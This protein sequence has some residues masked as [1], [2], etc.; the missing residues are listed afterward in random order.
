MTT[1]F[2]FT[3]EQKKQLAA[4]ESMKREQIETLNRR[5]IAYAKTQDKIEKLTRE[6]A[7]LDLDRAYSQRVL[8]ATESRIDTIVTEACDRRAEAKD[9]I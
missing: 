6:L 5:N 4:L 7:E 3:V 1:K 8:W 9:E 2:L